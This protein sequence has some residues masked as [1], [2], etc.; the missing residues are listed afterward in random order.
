M[1]PFPS[2]S[3]PPLRRGEGHASVVS[4]GNHPQE[5]IIEQNMSLGSDRRWHHLNSQINYAKLSDERL[6]RSR[7]RDEWQQQQQQNCDSS[8]TTT[9]K[10]CEPQIKTAGEIYNE[11][12]LYRTPQVFPKGY[13]LTGYDILCGRHKSAFNHVGNRRFRVTVSIFLS[14]YLRTPSRL[15]RSLIMMEIIDTIKEAGGHFLKSIKG[16][17]WIEICNK[18]IRNKVGHALRD[19]AAAVNAAANHKRAEIRSLKSMGAKCVASKRRI[20]TT[21]ASRENESVVA[22]KAKNEFDDMEF[23][24]L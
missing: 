12:T 3:Y 21:A 20:S 22:S 4:T 9:S 5:N 2:H 19:A 15:D 1:I 10:L 23:F 7:P 6:A 11:I 8:F 17:Q 24:D 18:E 16:G 14:R 13:K